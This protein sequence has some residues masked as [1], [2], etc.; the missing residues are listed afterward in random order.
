MK[1]GTNLLHWYQNP[2]GEAQVGHQFR[3]HQ[4]KRGKRK[5]KIGTRTLGRKEETVEVKVNRRGCL[6]ARRHLGPG[7]GS[8]TLTSGICRDVLPVSQLFRARRRERTPESEMGGFRGKKRIISTRPENSRASA[9]R[10]KKTNTAPQ[11]RMQ[12]VQDRGRGEQRQGVRIIILK[13]A[14]HKGE[15]QNPH[16]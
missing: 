15:G 4:K 5:K 8:G 13:K 16:R 7:R 12:D 9:R 6:R 10:H 14:A 3:N 1:K 2:K 11:I